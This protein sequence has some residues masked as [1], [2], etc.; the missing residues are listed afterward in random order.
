MLAD[1]AH[2]LN[3]NV[4]ILW[5]VMII[6]KSGLWISIFCALQLN[7]SYVSYNKAWNEVRQIVLAISDAKNAVRL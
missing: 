3:R 6:D 4:S 5:H 2:H 7:K 1:A